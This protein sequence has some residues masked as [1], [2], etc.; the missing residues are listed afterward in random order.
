MTRRV[1]SFY[2]RALTAADRTA[3]DDA[4]DVEGL[5]DEVALL[6]VQIRRL[7]ADEEPDPRVV[8]GAMRL[9]VQT[10]TAR[11]RL[12]G[13]QAE[14]L[15]DDAARLLEEFGAALAGGTVDT[16]GSAP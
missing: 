10:L 16:D 6:R 12:S 2:A 15:G 3:L 13:R 4:R 14:G 7:L 9:P 1:R 11:Q 8:Q 5:D